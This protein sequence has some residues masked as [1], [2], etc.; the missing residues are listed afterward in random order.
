M[1]EIK[2]LEYCFKENKLTI[3]IEQTKETFTAKL[4]VS[5]DKICI[6]SLDDKTAIK[7]LGNI[8]KII[9]DE[10]NQKILNEKYE[11]N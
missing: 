1:K 6:I 11:L 8:W 10:C 5:P 2:M 9:I 4:S 7:M 3:N